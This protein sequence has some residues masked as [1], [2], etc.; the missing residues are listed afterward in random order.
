MS[1]TGNLGNVH[2]SL[3]RYEEARVEHERAVKLAREIGDRRWEDLALHNLANAWS[4]LGG[5]ERACEFLEHSRDI[6][7]E[8]G[9]RGGM[10]YGDWLRGDLAAWTGDAERAEAML[11]H[12][13]EHFRAAGSV[14]EV[15]GT[16]V[17]LGQLLA[18]TARRTEAISHLQEAVRL[19]EGTD[20][21]GPAALARCHL[22]A[23]TGSDVGTAEAALR[24]CGP[25]LEHHQRLEARL[26][27][28]KATASL[29][30]LAA[31]RALLDHSLAN[32]PE[33]HHYAMLRC[34]PVNREVLE[35]ATRQ[36]ES[37]AE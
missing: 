8:I 18:P 35:C 21:C 6:A 31:A 26:L 30:H 23:L 22:A 29:E 12:A 9:D 37:A 4:Q 34:V 19:V 13:A 33:S 17:S 16:L 3:G 32:T 15:A 20:S 11:T 27:L 14:D 28:W 10:D 36:S 24:R 5:V 25:R 2:F 7:A 1:D